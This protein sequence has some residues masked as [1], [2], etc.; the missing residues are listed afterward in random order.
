MKF[1]LLVIS[2][3][4]ILILA[5]ISIARADNTLTFSPSL[6]VGAGL[7]ISPAK[8]GDARQSPLYALIQGSFINI[9]R[10]EG[11]DFKLFGLGV[12]LGLDVDLVVAPVSVC[13]KDEYCLS[14]HLAT[15]KHQYAGLGITFSFDNSKKK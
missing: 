5:A 3:T 1:I 12:S 8:G 7:R 2:M 10:S 14:A 15:G 11:A 13:L 6:G 4:L 9:E